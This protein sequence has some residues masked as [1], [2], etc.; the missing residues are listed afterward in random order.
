MPPRSTEPF[1]DLPGV[2]RRVYAGLR[3]ETL[4]EPEG[5]EVVADVLTW[6]R[7]NGTGQPPVD[8]SV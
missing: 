8:R 3:H 6:L 2:T 7:A 5:P 4:N 1:R